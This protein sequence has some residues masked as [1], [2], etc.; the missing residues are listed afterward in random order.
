M[1]RD[2]SLSFEAAIVALKR[3]YEAFKGKIAAANWN[4]DMNLR[5]FVIDS[6]FGV[7]ENGA[8]ITDELIK[9]R[10]KA[11]RRMAEGVIRSMQDGKDVVAEPLA[12]LAI[13]SWIMAKQ[14]GEIDGWKDLNVKFGVLTLPAGV[15]LDLN[16]SIP[17]EAPPVTL[18]PKDVTPDFAAGRGNSP[19]TSAQQQ[20]A[21]AADDKQPAS[22][23]SLREKFSGFL[24]LKK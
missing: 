20:P 24:G 8:K 2:P 23:N 4:E 5:G 11:F 6:L 18:T 19:A 7:P 9:L 16:E 14:M 17:V 21:P 1:T 10:V 22:S 12:T 15:T 3:N 13:K